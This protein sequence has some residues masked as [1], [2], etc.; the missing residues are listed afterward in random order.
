MVSPQDKEHTVRSCPLKPGHLEQPS[1]TPTATPEPRASCFPARPEEPMRDV[2]IGSDVPSLTAPAKGSRGGEVASG[3]A[4]TSECPVGSA[5]EISHDAERSW[6]L[7]RDHCDQRSFDFPEEMEDS[8]SLTSERVQEDGHTLSPFAGFRESSC[9]CGWALAFYGGDCFGEEVIKY[10]EKLG[11]HNEEPTMEAKKQELHQQ[12]MIERRNLKKTQ[13][14][15]QKLLHQEKKNKGSDAR[16]MLSKL[17]VQ[18]E[19]LK[20]KVEFLDSVKKY[21]EVL[22]RDQWGLDTPLLPSLASSGPAPLELLP[23]EDSSMLSLQPAS[24]C[25]RSSLLQ[26]GTPLGLVSYLYSRNAYLE[27]YIQQFLYTFRYFCTPQD[28]LQFLMDKFSSSAGQEPSADRTKVHQRTLDL[29][30]SWME[31]CLPLDFPTKSALQQTLENFLTSQHSAQRCA[32]Q[33]TLLQQEMFQGCHP[34]HFLNSRAQGV[35]D[36]AACVTKVLAS[37]AQL[38]ESSSLFV[39]DAAVQ[40]R[41]LVQLLK[42]DD[43]V[44]NWVS[45]EIVIC[46]SIKT[47]AGLLSKFLTIA[48][49]CY[50]SRNFATA[51][52]ILGG[53]ENVIVRQLPAWKHLS[54]KACEVLEELKAVQVFLK[55]DNLCLTEGEQFKK[56]PTLPATHILAMHVQQLE[57][58]AFT[59]ASGAFKWPKLRNIAKM[60]SQVHAFQENRFTYTPDQELQGYLR[61]RISRLS[62]CNVTLLAAENDANFHQIL[63]DRHSKKIQDTLRRMKATFQ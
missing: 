56:L 19:E 8:D 59:L 38:G 6:H 35:R 29:L 62:D 48:K 58:G 31:D 54:A 11:Q 23:C 2:A 44:S 50:E 22:C 51:M 3:H 33:L 1:E 40:D 60:V 47:Q 12:L 53:L 34:I 45:A 14:F 16:M 36:K 63:N 42:Y 5:A 21:L 32:Q 28:F 9:H 43:H 41:R 17:Q 13:N 46:D 18:L 39:Q 49:Y 57:I 27:G 26:A 20:A 61:H 30:Q 7:E 37:D 52:Q 10:M 24:A 55:S 4:N 25:G 15:Y